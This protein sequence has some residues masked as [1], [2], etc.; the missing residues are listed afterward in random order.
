MSYVGAWDAIPRAVCHRA[1]GGE[2]GYWGQVQLQRGRRRCPTC[3][4]SG[5]EHVEMQFLRRIC[6]APDCDGKRYRP[7]ILEV[8]IGAG[9]FASTWPMCWT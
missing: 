7:E 5:F 4:G 6:A 3:G 9:A 1:A 8:R 2:R